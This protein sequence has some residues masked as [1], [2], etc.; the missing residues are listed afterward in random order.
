MAIKFD[1][2]VR[3]TGSN[4]LRNITLT[5]ATMITVAVSLALVGFAL[6][7]RQ[8]VSNATDRWKGDVEFIVYMQ[9]DAQPAQIDAV[10]NDLSSNPEVKEIQYL[11]HEAAYREFV[12]LFKDEPGMY[13][14]ITPDALP[15]SFKVA[16]VTVDADLIRA[17]SDQFEKKPGVRQVVS[18]NDTIKTMQRV[19]GII[20]NGIFIG[21]LI[22]GIAAVVLITN[23]IRTAMFARR[24]EIE[25]MK[26]VGATNWFIRIPFMLEGLVQAVVG[27]TVAVGSVFALNAYFEDKL[28][29]ANNNLNLLRSFVV[30]PSAVWGTSAIVV[31]IGLFVGVVGS[32]LAVTRFLDV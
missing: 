6:L 14:S 32:G 25:V 26:L 13:E 19:S 24:R 28:D 1:Y 16:P 12:E 10:R 22:L 2:V 15:T 11:D 5:L 21:A 17:L 23:T 9:P 30:E 3:E 31:L 20:S 18:A 27:A 7:L 8:G 4:L 29:G